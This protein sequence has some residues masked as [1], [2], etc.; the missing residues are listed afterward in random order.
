MRNWNPTIFVQ[1]EEMKG[2]TGT[3][4]ER[5]LGFQNRNTNFDSCNAPCAKVT[6]CSWNFLITIRGWFKGMVP[7]TRRVQCWQD[8]A[9]A[10]HEY[11]RLLDALL[12]LVPLVVI[13]GEFYLPCLQY[14]QEYKKQCL[15]PRSGD[16]SGSILCLEEFWFENFQAFRME[17]CSMVT[18]PLKR[19]QTAIIL[20]F[21]LLV[22]KIT[23]PRQECLETKAAELTGSQIKRKIQF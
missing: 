21:R 7:V 13:S 18:R 6:E 14:A 8:E 11:L 12:E 17:S 15:K 23:G 10:I 2:D 16:F 9:T 5:R 3:L 20:S 4:N 19:T 22:Y 1:K